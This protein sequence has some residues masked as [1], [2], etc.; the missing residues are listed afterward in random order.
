MRH[1]P[2]LPGSAGVWG[3][4]QASPLRGPGRSVNR[5]LR[6]HPEREFVGIYDAPRSF[7]QRQNAQNVLIAVQDADF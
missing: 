1:E 2:L 7:R 5:H 6:Q 4:F 3:A